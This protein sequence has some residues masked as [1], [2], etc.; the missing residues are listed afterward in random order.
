[1]TLN[2]L[3]SWAK[4]RSANHSLLLGLQTVTQEGV[5]FAGDVLKKQESCHW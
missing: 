5:D 2:L 3:D 1:M 4:H